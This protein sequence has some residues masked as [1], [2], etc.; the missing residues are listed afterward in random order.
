MLL[1]HYCEAAATHT[2]VI[3]DQNPGSEWEGFRINRAL[4][5]EHKDIPE[6]QLARGVKGA[7]LAQPIVRVGAQPV[8]W[9]GGK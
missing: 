9:R 5:G 6:H 3:V 8:V 2:G 7:E 1:C 4:C